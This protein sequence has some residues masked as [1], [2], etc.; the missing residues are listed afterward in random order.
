MWWK[1]AQ[2]EFSLNLFSARFN[3]SLLLCLLLIPIT[4][5][6]SLSDYSKRL[7][8]YHV[9]KENAENELKQ[10]RVYS[11][12]KPLLG[13]PSEAFEH[14]VPGYFKPGWS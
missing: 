2:K 3:I 7:S 8:T 10:A 13:F 6:V 4:I 1:I 9:D 5:V 11:A 14:I 12:V